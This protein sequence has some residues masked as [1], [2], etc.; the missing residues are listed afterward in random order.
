MFMKALEADAKDETAN[1]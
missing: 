1:T